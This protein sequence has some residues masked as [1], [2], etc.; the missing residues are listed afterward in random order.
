MGDCSMHVITADGY[1]YFHAFYVRLRL[2][3]LA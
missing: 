1:T 2:F 3:I